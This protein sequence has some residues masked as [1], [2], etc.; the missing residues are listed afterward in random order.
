M[1]LLNFYYIIVLAW[2]IFYLSYS[3][4][5]DLAWASCN[6]TWNTGNKWPSKYTR[7]RGG[8]LTFFFDAFNYN[9]LLVFSFFSQQTA[10]SYRGE[11]PQLNKQSTRMPP[12]P[13]SSSGSEFYAAPRL[14]LGDPRA[15]VKT[16]AMHHL[17]VPLSVQE[18]SAPDFPGPRPHGLSELGPGPVSVHCLGHVLLLHLEGGEIHR[19]GG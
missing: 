15:V 1:T 16:T 10:W 2:G 9:I 7:V 18:K 14:T 17:R 11:T 5:W 6:N 3:F 19:K 4:S 13:S 12:L 8:P